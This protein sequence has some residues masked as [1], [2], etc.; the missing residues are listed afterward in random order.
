MMAETCEGLVRRA[1]RV[2][3]RRFCLRTLHPDNL[4]RNFIWRQGAEV[5]V[6]T[7]DFNILQHG[8]QVSRWRS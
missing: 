7:V 6:A 4:W 2:A 8:F 5:E 1:A 3:G